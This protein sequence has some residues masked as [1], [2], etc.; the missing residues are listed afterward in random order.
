MINEVLVLGIATTKERWLLL[1]KEYELSVQENKPWIS[2]SHET[3]RGVSNKLDYFCS[4]HDFHGSASGAALKKSK[5]CPQCQSEDHLYKSEE[6]SE[7][8]RQ[9]EALKFIDKATKLHNDKY[10][11][12]VDWYVSRNDALT[13]I[14]CNTHQEFFYQRPAAHL[15]G[16]NCPKCGKES[17]KVSARYTQEEFISLVS[18]VNKNPLLDFSASKYTHMHEKVEFFCSKHGVKNKVANFLIRQSQPCEDCNTELKRL[19]NEQEFIR[20]GKII[21]NDNY[22]YSLVDG[23]YKTNRTKLPI[24]CKVHKTISYITK[25][26]HIDRKQGGCKEC[27]KSVYGRWNISTLKKNLSHHYNKPC[28][29]YLLKINH[30]DLVFYKVGIT[31]DITIR[32]RQILE[33]L[34]EAK[35]NCLIQSWSNVV[36]SVLLE[37][38]LLKF[39]KNKKYEHSVRFG[40]YTECFTPTEEDILNLYH[41]MT[42]PV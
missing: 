29:T 25:N 18:E 15:R 28:C 16:Q 36:E 39:I 37:K 11:Y 38:Y 40:G 2:I 35:I 42:A 19:A 27:A 30:N 6:F 26:H 10:T 17:F 12:H 33:E 7:I 9:K 1:A 3:Y 32:V 31:S 13:K 4:R 20:L 21:H 8:V 24:I 23:L 22:D 41:I 14:W 5:G 34:P